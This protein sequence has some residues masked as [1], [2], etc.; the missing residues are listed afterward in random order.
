MKKK[1]MNDCKPS[2]TESFERSRINCENK[3]KKIKFLRF[4]EPIYWEL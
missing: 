1:I 4:F 2:G 3:V